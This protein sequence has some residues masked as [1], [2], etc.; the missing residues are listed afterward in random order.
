MRANARS[1]LCAQQTPARTRVRPLEMPLKSTRAGQPQWKARPLKS[2]CSVA[3]STLSTVSSVVESVLVLSAVAKY[4]CRRVNSSGWMS[5]WIL[6][7]IGLGSLSD[8][9]LAFFG[10]P[11]LKEKTRS[12][13]VMWVF[14][15]RHPWGPGGKL[16]QS[17]WHSKEMAAR[18]IVLWA[19]GSWREQVEAEESSLANLRS[20]ATPGRGGGGQADPR[21][22]AAAVKVCAPVRGF[23]AGASRH[24]G[25]EDDEES[26]RH[27][28]TQAEVGDGHVVRA[29]GYAGLGRPCLA[30]ATSRPSAQRA[31]SWAATLF[32]TGSTRVVLD[33]RLQP[34]LLLA[35]ETAGK[36]PR[37]FVE[38]AHQRCRLDV[39]CRAA[40]NCALHGALTWSWRRGQPRPGCWMRTQSSKSSKSRRPAGKANNSICHRRKY[41]STSASR[42]GKADGRKFQKYRKHKILG[43]TRNR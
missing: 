15:Y 20:G 8:L 11:L 30:G 19:G 42:A 10:R 33:I 38:L 23:A 4:R 22:S 35:T 12:N 41:I 16:N 26:D 25:V 43:N 39:T 32:I 9:L 28:V 6:S 17:A 14:R 36:V 29:C 21:H 5:F 18:A 2:T 37:P 24:F 27:P 34:C 1:G 3:V 13:V 7:K 31:A 40:S